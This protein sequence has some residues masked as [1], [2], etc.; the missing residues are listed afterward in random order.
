MHRILQLSSK[1]FCMFVVESKSLPK[2]DSN[3]PRLTTQWQLS[4]D[5]ILPVLKQVLL[6]DCEEA[7]GWV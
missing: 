5:P 1:G 7:L 4:D 3:C 2:A 6:G